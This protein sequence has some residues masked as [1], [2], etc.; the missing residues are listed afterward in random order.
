MAGSEAVVT[1]LP[2]AEFVGDLYSFMPWFKVTMGDESS[3]IFAGNDSHQRSQ[4]GET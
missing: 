2:D 4:N 3:R 1:Y